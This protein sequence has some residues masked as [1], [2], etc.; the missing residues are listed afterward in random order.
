MMIVLKVGLLVQY[1]FQMFLVRAQMDM[2]ASENMDKVF[3]L[4]I[5]TNPDQENKDRVSSYEG[6]TMLYIKGTG[7][8]TEMASN[9]LVLIGELTCNIEGTE[10]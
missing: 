7:F 3:I 8:D 1:L 9:N 4:S 2:E 5:S 6:G 10:K